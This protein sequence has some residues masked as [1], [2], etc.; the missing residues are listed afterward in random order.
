MDRHWKAHLLCSDCED[1]LSKKGETWVCPRLGWADRRFP[2]FDLLEKAGGFHDRDK[3]EGVY[4]A[5]NNS[6]IDV[7]KFL[8]FAFGILWRAGVHSWIGKIKP[9]MVELGLYEERIRFWLHGT[10]P[11]PGMAA[12][13]LVVSRP[14]RMQLTL[15]QPVQIPAA[16]QWNQ[17]MFYALGVLFHLHVGD[18]VGFE[19]RFMCFYHNPQHPVLLS[20]YVQDR[21]EFKLAAQFFESRKTAA[22]L[23]AMAKWREKIKV[24]SANGNRTRILALKGLRA[25]RCTIAPHFYF[26]TAIFST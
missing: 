20:N 15:T 24:G 23:R 17:Y 2:L 25:N 3:G 13:N 12:L 9:T 19:E 18:I 5:A 22:Y 11:F 8:H 26:T 10:G 7:E 16:T 4:H 14:D 6:E 21:H 1:I